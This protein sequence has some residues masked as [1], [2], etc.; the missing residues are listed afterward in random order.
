LPSALGRLVSMQFQPMLLGRRA[1]AFDHPDWLFELKHDGFRALASFANGCCRL[2][3]RNRNEF[4]SFGDLA[5]ALPHDLRTKSAVMDGEIVCLDRD[6]RSDFASLF[7]RRA[8]P[9]FVA[10]DLLAV[11]GRDLR[12][13]PLIE[14]KAELRRTLRPHLTRTLYCDHIEHNGRGLFHL[15]CEHDLEG[16]IAKWKHGPYIAGREET[17]WF[18]IRNREYSQWEGRDEMF[19]RH[20]EPQEITPE[21]WESCVAACEEMTL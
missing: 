10:F 9:I 14:R 6:G 4:K 16:I 1:E 8:E 21:A 11:G 17:T 20:Q 5:L 18:K 12:T 19:E 2:I 13:L 3:S 7:Y 15:A